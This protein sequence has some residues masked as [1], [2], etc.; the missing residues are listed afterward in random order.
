MV[1]LIL[2]IEMFHQIA[3]DNNKSCI[4]TD[5]LLYYLFLFDYKYEYLKI[6]YE[7]GHI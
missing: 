4:K 5:N 7:L 6:Y 3:L 2:F 1:M